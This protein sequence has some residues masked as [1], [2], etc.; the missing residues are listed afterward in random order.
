MG[1]AR[2]VKS[3]E[4]QRTSGTSQRAGND[5]MNWP[6]SAAHRMNYSLAEGYADLLAQVKVNIACEKC[7]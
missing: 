5:I 6:S 1:C 4:R 2:P 3:G 7:V